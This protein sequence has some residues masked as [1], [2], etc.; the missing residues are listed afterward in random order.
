MLIVANKAFTFVSIIVCFGLAIYIYVWVYIGFKI[1][2]ASKEWAIRSKKKFFESNIEEVI[3]HIGRIGDSNCM[4]QVELPYK[5][6]R[7]T[8]F[9]LDFCKYPKLKDLNRGDFMVKNANSSICE[10]KLKNGNEFKIEIEI[11]Y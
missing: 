4:N 3:T 6:D 1:N 2:S 7:I 8:S 5:A 10:F 11:E 9:S